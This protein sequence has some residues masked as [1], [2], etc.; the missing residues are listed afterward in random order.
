MDL[1]RRSVLLLVLT[2]CGDDRGDKPVNV[3]LDGYLEGS[4]QTLPVGIVGEPYEAYLAVSGGDAPYTWEVAEWDSLPGGLRLDPTGEVKGTPT[5]AG[6]FTVQMSATDASGRQKN[7]LATVTV[8][9]EPAILKCGETAEGTFTGTG[10]GPVLP[11]FSDETNTLWFGVELPTDA[12]SRVELV[13]DIDDPVTVFVEKPTEL[14]GDWDLEEHYIA[15]YLDPTDPFEPITSVRIDAG[16]NP[17]LSGFS[18]QALLPWLLVAQ[19]SGDWKVTVECSDGPVF[20]SVLAYP[21]EIGQEIQINYDVY[22]SQEGV[23]IWTDDDLPDWIVWDETTGIVT[24]TALETGGWEFTLK[25]EDAAGNVREE[26]AI[27]SVYDVTDVACGGSAPV[28]IGEGYY[29]GEF[30][31]YFDT[32]GYQIFRV[33]ID[34]EGPTSA[35]TATLGDGDTQLLASVLNNDELFKFYPGAE[36]LYTTGYPT[37]LL[38]D[39]RSYPAIKHYRIDGHVYFIASTLGI[40]TSMT[41]SIDCDDTPRPDLAGLPVF[42]PLT[43]DAF[44]LDAVGGTSP[45]GWSAVGLPAGISLDTSGAL[46]GSTPEVGTSDVDVTVVDKLGATHTEAYPFFVGYDEACAGAIYLDCGDTYEGDFTQSYFSDPN[47]SSASTA[48]FCV[49]YD[50]DTTLGYAIEADDTQLRVDVVDPGATEFDLYTANRGTYVAFVDRHDRE[51]VA[52]NPWNWPN[53]EDYRNLPV[54]VVVRAYDSGAFSTTL[55]CE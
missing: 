41:L 35:I 51:G 6:T 33:A 23:R 37:E 30:T 21:T 2:A 1:I 15:T 43:S 32:K 19:Q 17:S 8:I 10:W 39:P 13:F 20:Q 9:L 36:R 26:P 55:T 5:Q 3:P 40:D 50:K 25:A 53:L 29:D 22:G 44:A 12:T 4:D 49:V 45:W 11:D 52:L 42:E 18:S 54:R 7:L 28:E 14:V 31:S 47:Y 16:T 38:I 24:G 27:I 34:P 46:A 48:V